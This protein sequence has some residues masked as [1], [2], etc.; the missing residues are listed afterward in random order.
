MSKCTAGLIR[1][2]FGIY[3][4]T[5]TC[6]LRQAL[7]HISTMYDQKHMNTYATSIKQT[8]DPIY[9]DEQLTCPDQIV[10]TARCSCCMYI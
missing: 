1:S 9:S 2:C 6:D 5:T 8:V 4:N 7:W 3:A 10:A